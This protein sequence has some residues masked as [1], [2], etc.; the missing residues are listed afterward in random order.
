M[1]RF[2]NVTALYAS[3]SQDGYIRVW[4]LKVTQSRDIPPVLLWGY[5]SAYYEI[6]IGVSQESGLFSGLDD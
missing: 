5:D 2:T 1:L 6:F 3:V 4:Q